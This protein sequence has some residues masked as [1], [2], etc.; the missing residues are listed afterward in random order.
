MVKGALI[1]GPIESPLLL[2]SGKTARFDGGVDHLYMAV[3]GETKA[4][5]LLLYSSN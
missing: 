3:G 5:V 4:V 2:W 1:A